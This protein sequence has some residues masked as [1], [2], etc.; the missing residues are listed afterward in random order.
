MNETER[1]AGEVHRKIC[2]QAALAA[3]EEKI[4]RIPV[5]ER[6]VATMMRKDIR[7]INI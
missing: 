7:P 4:N 6:S 5:D 3:V 2:A 1:S